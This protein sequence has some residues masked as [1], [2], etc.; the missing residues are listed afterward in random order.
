[1]TG[2]LHLGND[3]VLAEQRVVRHSAAGNVVARLSRHRDDVVLPFGRTVGAEEDG[4]VHARADRFVHA[5]RD[6]AENVEI[7]IVENRF[8]NRHDDGK[9]C[10]RKVDV[11][12]R[13]LRG[14]L[15]ARVAVDPVGDGEHVQYRNAGLLRGHVRQLACQR[16]ENGLLRCVLKNGADNLLLNQSFSTC[17]VDDVCHLNQSFFL[18][19]TLRMALFA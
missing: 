19:N 9:L 10:R 17:A 2:F 11:V 18:P 4:G 13:L 6:L 7:G 1:M 8:R 12:P 15:K 5:G 14:L 3:A 16:H